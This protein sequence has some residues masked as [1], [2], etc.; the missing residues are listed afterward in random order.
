M[1][2]KNLRYLPVTLLAIQFLQTAHADDWPQWRGPDR[3][4]ISKEGGLLA[5]WPESGPPLAWR[6]KGLGTGFSS[7]AV[8]NGKLYTLGD[9]EDGSYAIALSEKDGSPLWKTKIGEAGGHRK[10]PGTRSTPT[11]DNGQ[12]FVLNQ[13]S[14]LA[15]LD[16]SS[17]K[18]LWRK[19]LVSEFGGK[20]MSGWKYSE[21][22]LVDGDRVVC[23]PGGKDGTLLAVDRNNGAKLW[24]TSDW[25]DPAG[26]SS[27]VIA[28]IHGT[29]QYVQ[30]TGAS[31]AG[32]EPSSGKVLW[33]A[34]RAGKTAVIPTP[35]I[36][37]DLVFV[38][39][40][41]GIG[42]NGFRVSKDGD[43]WSAEEIY[44]NKEIANHHGGVVLVDG[45]VYGA[46][47]S[48]FRCVEL[49]SGDGV[50]NERSAGKG[51][52]LYADGRFILRSENGPVALMEASPEGMREI[53]RF[54]QPDRSKHRAWPHP[55]IANG[56]LYLRDQ[57]LLLCYDVGAN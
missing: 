31:V 54:D 24:Q 21:S 47:G 22:P 15:C 46:T 32:V 30:L 1:K 2:T 11:V 39:S 36:D 18:L 43:A 5:E 48:T 57:G 41:Y 56:K 40:G 37:G 7:I 17:G 8:A 26:Y 52:T 51:S 55:V 45:H 53:S 4:G 28:T 49:E 42:C 16:A 44:A 20:M 10:Y 14:D 23:T 34:K 50:F 6:G 27:V 35:I 19:N 25:T 38:T 13:H 29:K 12:V 33:Q 9:L 3:D